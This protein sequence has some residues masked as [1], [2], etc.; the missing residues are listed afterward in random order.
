MRPYRVSTL[1]AAAGFPLWALAIPEGRT[2][3]SAALW[4][5]ILDMMLGR[6]PSTNLRTPI[7]SACL[8]NSSLELPRL[9]GEQS[10]QYNIEEVRPEGE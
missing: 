6:F 8:Q 7:C 4:A 10:C 2:P 5:D 3:I 9:T 1:R